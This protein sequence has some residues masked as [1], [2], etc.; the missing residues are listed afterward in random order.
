M[1]KTVLQLKKIIAWVLI[2]KMTGKLI[3]LFHNKSISFEGT[4]IYVED[5]YIKDEVIASLY[6]R[7]YESAE[8]RFIKKY[9]NSNLPVVELGSSMGVVGQQIAKKNVPVL[10]CVEPNRRLLAIIQKNFELNNN[11]N[12]KVINAA[13]SNG[14]QTANFM[15]GS[16]NLDSRIVLNKSN[17]STEIPATNLTN[18]LIR[19]DIKRCN[20]ICDI[21]GAEVFLLHFD[22][23]GIRKCETIIIET[24]FFKYDEEMFTP[25][26]IKNLFLDMGFNMIDEYG[27][28]LVLK[29]KMLEG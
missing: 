2:N 1:H 17:A 11:S 19:N 28:V 24:H 5:H 15:E 13:I 27:P 3:R 23:D 7:T 20:L 12:Y 9:L 8:I 29:N 4:E 18:I 16:S 21:E 26:I 14:K 25:T 10:L 6:F 22:K